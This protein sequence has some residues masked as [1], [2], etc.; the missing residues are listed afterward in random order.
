MGLATFE[1][2]RGRPVRGLLYTLAARGREDVGGIRN[3]TTFKLLSESDAKICSP[4]PG[5]GSAQLDVNPP[6]PKEKKKKNHRRK[7]T[8]PPP[9]KTASNQEGLARGT[10]VM[11]MARVQ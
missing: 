3:G 2:L 1:Y 11:A 7:K 10:T 4:I 9:R 6:Q 5:T 8:V